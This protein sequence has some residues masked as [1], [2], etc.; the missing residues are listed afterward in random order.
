[1]RSLSRVRYYVG[2]RVGGSPAGMGWE[3]QAVSLVP[4][5]RL[6]EAL[7]RTIDHEIA[8]AAGAGPKP[9][10][11]GEVMDGWKKVGHQSGSNPGG[12][13]QDT[14]GKKWY[15]KFP[16]SVDHAKNELLASKLYGLAGIETPELKLVNDDGNVGIASA[17]TEGLQTDKEALQ[18]GAAEGAREGFGT[19]AW[20]A[21]WDSVGLV[22]DNM[23]LDQD[24]KAVRI[25]P[26]GSLLYRA[27]GSPKGAAFGNTVTEI[28]SLR[29]PKVNAQAASVF[30]NMTE[31]D[32]KASV[33]PVL[34]IPQESIRKTVMECGPGGEKEREAL[35][36]KLIA[37]QKDLAQRFG[38]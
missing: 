37:R 29:D 15:V 3:A 30:G 19:D 28:D 13:Y 34:A 25:D 12:L 31:A 17:F 8:M 36:D 27:Q 22:Y 10:S 33:A 38:K 11:V 23:L 26:G 21:N 35:A 2:K 32:L 6:Y 16:K 14:S 1:D 18:E 20:L 7:N 9:K 5:E 24:G 4:K